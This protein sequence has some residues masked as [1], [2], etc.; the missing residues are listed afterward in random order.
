MRYLR[1]SQSCWFVIWGMGG[2]SQ[3]GSLSRHHS[4]SPSRAA[5]SCLLCLS[6]PGNTS[7]L[8]HLQSASLKQYPTYNNRQRGSSVLSADLL[9][10]RHWE[11]REWNNH[12]GNASEEDF[13]IF[14]QA[15]ASA[16]LQSN[17]AL[18]PSLKKEFLM[19]FAPGG[20]KIVSV[21]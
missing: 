2:M 12:Q 3:L 14:S 5:P 13:Q 6:L 16:S 18:N 19:L 17:R 10:I 11:Q 7:C 4:S 15:R 20:T 8:F 1:A 9:N 21:K